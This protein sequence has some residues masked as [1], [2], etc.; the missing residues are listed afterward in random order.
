[1]L[2]ISLTTSLFTLLAHRSAILL[3]MSLVVLLAK[4]LAIPLVI[5]LAEMLTS[6]IVH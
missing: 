2:A 1:M 3:A 6:D 5:V 4:M